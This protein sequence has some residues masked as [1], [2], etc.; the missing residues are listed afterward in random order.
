[1]STSK[2]WAVTYTRVSSDEQEKDG[3]SIPAQHK[4]LRSY[5]DAHGIEIRQEYE[6]VETAKKAG[7]PAFGEMVAFLKHEAKKP[8]DQCCRIILVEKTDRLYRNIRDYVTLDELDTDIHFVKENTQL[9]PKSHSSEK[10]MHGIKV[11]M[12]KNYIDNL[13]EE[14]KKGLLEKAE[15][16]IWPL[17]API[18]YRS[19]DSSTGKKLIERDPNCAPA[20]ERLF[21]EYA[22]GKFS[23]DELVAIA[24]EEGL[25]S[26]K[27]RKPIHKAHVHKILCNP[28]YYGQF[29]WRGRLYA[30]IH[31]P[32]VTG[33]LW[34]KVQMILRDRGTKK[35]KKRKH[36]FAFSGL[37][38]CGHCDCAVVGELQKGRYVYY[39]CSGHKGKCPEA[40]VREEVLEEKFTSILRRLSFD[41]EILDWVSSALRESHAD[42]KKLH[43]EAIDR[44]QSEYK[45]LQRRIEAAYDDKL[46]GRID[47]GF[48]DR[49]TSEWRDE[50]SR[51][52]ES[53]EQHENANRSYMDQGIAL[54]E[55]ASRAVELFEKQEPREKRRLLDFVLSNCTWAGGELTPQFRQ[56]FDMIADAATRCAKEKVAGATSDDLRLLMGG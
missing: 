6:D 21:E 9:S 42:E 3:F 51:V 47:V 20:I 32:L 17:R 12:A 50:Q 10:F 23:L 54:F 34:D 27:S 36:N 4:L 41:R 18:G 25:V 31:E 53:I 56:P 45:R 48:Y 13:S 16:G 38:R 55:L 14:T 28:L 52:R 39:H 29:K 8:R 22:T 7:R 2:I 37:V 30:G 24:R 49:K 33:E 11:L 46:D 19:I 15:Q 26:P 40:Y 43:A 1:M 5:A 44:L 35:P